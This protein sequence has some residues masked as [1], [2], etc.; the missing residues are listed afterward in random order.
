MAHSRYRTSRYRRSSHVR[1]SQYVPISKAVALQQKASTEASRFVRQAFFSLE[2]ARLERY[3]A[4]YA[5]E[6]GATSAAYARKTYDKWRSGVVGMSPETATRLL[7]IVPRIL[8]RYDQL[9]LLEIYVPYL[10]QSLAEMFLESLRRE[11]IPALE[12]V[13]S[14][15]KAEEMAK[16]VPLP[17]DWFVKGVFTDQ[18]LAHFEEVIR[19][20][21][22][23]RL[24]S[25]FRSVVSDLITLHNACAEK[26]FAITLRYQIS[27]LGAQVDLESAQGVQNLDYRPSFYID[28]PKVNKDVQSMIV[29]NIANILSGDEATEQ[30]SSGM[31]SIA[32]NELAATLDR[33]EASRNSETNASLRIEAKGGIAFLEITK[34]SLQLLRQKIG[35]AR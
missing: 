35:A 6:N 7:K 8:P 25:S 4:Q 12:L 15:Q 33:V 11:I 13:S 30:R 10:Q 32:L 31:Q 34:L 27:F 14:Y 24:E 22:I 9:K 3:F 1:L 5:N 16:K 21:L 26:P 29:R 19:F 2:P 18:E 17:V 23:H 20:L 28:Q